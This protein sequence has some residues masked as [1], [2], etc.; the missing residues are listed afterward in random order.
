MLRRTSAARSAASVPAPLSASDRAR[1]HAADWGR[2]AALRSSPTRIPYTSRVISIRSPIRDI[3]RPLPFPRDRPRLGNPPVVINQY[4]GAPDPNQGFA[5]GFVPGDPNGNPAYRSGPPEPPP[6]T[7]ASSPQ[8][9]DPIGPAQNYYLIAYKDHSVYPA[10]AYWVEDNTLNYVT[11]QNTHNQ[12][13]LNLIDLEL[14][15]TLNQARSVP[16]SIPGIGTRS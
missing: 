9:G 1:T 2:G 15:K 16:F 11:T 3:T 5:P 12:A 6:A 7:G 4:F 10:L 14:T 13:S 8:P